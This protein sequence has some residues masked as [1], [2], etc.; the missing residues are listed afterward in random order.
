M[1]AK[2]KQLSAR[3]MAMPKRERMLLPGA[4]CFAIL[5]LGHLLLIEPARKQ[6]KLISQQYQQEQNDLMVVQ[7][8]VKVLNAKLKNPDAELHTQIDGLRT[9]TRAADDQF[10][11]L[12]SSLVPAQEMS[13]WLAGLLQAQ[14]GLQLTGLRSLPVTSV[15][16]LLAAKA[17][18]AGTM[19][20]AGVAVAAVP[21]AD[22]ASAATSASRDT[23]LYRHGVE[24]T[25]RGNYADLL[26][27]L[28]TL[29]HLPRHVYW[30]ELKINAQDSPAVVMTLTVYTISLEKTWWVI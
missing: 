8:Q 1:K 4:L 24:V 23:W 20:S 21:P 25:L 17:A 12:Q 19:A 27:Y 5:M 29:E 28:N 6:L 22:S 30:G 15:A 10:K 9:Q 16:D 14:R 2:W 13:Q 3:F 11:Q 18:P 26:A 7:T